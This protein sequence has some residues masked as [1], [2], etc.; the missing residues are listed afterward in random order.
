MK[1]KIP[2]NTTSSPAMV[3][4]MGRLNS[5]ERMRNPSRVL[6]PAWFAGLVARFYGAADGRNM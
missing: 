3:R 2:P 6:R 4:T 1:P 5:R